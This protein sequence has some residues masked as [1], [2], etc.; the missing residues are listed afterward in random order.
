[1][2][3]DYAHAVGRCREVVH[4]DP[5]V[6]GRRARGSSPRS[7][8]R[9]PARQPGFRAVPAAAPPTPS[10]TRGLFVFVPSGQG[11]NFMKAVRRERALDKAGIKLIGPGDLRDPT[12]I[13]CPNMGDAGDRRR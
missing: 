10:P 12:T 2:V 1:M 5:R 9:F 6:N 8:S 13:C 4:Q 11:G 7:A 3:S